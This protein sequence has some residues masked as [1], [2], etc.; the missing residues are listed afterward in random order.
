MQVFSKFIAGLYCKENTIRGKTRTPNEHTS[1][2]ICDVDLGTCRWVD[3]QEID[4]CGCDTMSK[5]M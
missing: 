3:A 5:L 1:P 4:M 2:T